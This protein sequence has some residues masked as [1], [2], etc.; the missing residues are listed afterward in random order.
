[1][2][3]D[4]ITQWSYGIDETLTLLM[5]DFKGGGSSSILERDG[6]EGLKGYDDFY[7]LCHAVA[8]GHRLGQYPGHQPVLG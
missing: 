3:R 2:A 4:Y 8:A 7:Q 6:V 1:M 5:P